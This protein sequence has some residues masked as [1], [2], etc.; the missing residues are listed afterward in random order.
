MRRENE[1]A[2]RRIPLLVLIAP[3]VLLGLALPVVLGEIS[4]T[5]GIIAD[6]VMMASFLLFVF[7]IATRDSRDRARADTEERARRERIRADSERA[8]ARMF[9]DPRPEA[10]STT[11]SR[12]GVVRGLKNGERG[13]AYGD[14]S[15]YR[16]VGGKIYQG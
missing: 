10:S 8:R 3:L 7:V 5:L 1:S 15:A 13:A 12:R 9:G 11:A 16:G 4:S 2:P 6:G 14:E